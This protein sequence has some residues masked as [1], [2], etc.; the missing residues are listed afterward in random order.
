MREWK[1]QER[2]S[3]WKAQR[4]L[5]TKIM[6]FIKRQQFMAHRNAAQRNVVVSWRLL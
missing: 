2:Q 4:N 5:T 1:T 3:I 6:A